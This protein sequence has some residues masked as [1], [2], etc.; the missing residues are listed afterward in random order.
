LLAAALHVALGAAALSR[1]RAPA[2][3]DDLAF[4]T[5]W[6]RTDPEAAQPQVGLGQWYAERGSLDESRAHYEAAIAL[7]PDYAVAHAS[8]GAVLLAHGQDAEA[9]RSLERAASLAP[10]EA[11]TWSNLGV[12]LARL[13]RAAEAERAYGRALAL[14]PG[15]A[16][17]RR[18][19]DALREPPRSRA[20]TPLRR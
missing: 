17:A 8:L 1:V 11:T 19:L 10:D 6:L 12:A 3:A 9:A 5:Q 7:R 20:R 16:A 14:E 18:N 15:L 13:G 2:W 4:H